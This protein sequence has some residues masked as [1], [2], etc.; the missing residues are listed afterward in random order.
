MTVR[1]HHQNSQ[2]IVQ[3]HSRADVLVAFPRLQDT[4]ISELVALHADIVCQFRR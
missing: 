2:E 4:I 1:W 3:R